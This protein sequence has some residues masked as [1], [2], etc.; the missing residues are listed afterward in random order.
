MEI[1]VD[2]S[3][4]RNKEQQTCKSYL[5]IALN[6]QTFLLHKY[7]SIQTTMD[8][9]VTQSIHKQSTNQIHL[10]SHSQAHLETN[11][12]EEKTWDSSLDFQLEFLAELSSLEC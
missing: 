3:I 10:Q 7:K 4:Y 2:V 5:I 9:H 8:L 11:A 12:V 1:Q 6:K